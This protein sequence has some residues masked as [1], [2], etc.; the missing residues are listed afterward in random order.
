[1]NGH[2][3]LYVL[4]ALMVFFWSANFVVAKWVLR[5][6]PPLLLS[7]LR[8]AIAGAVITPVYWWQ[9]R[10]AAGDVWGK[11]DLPVLL[12]LGLFGVALNQLFFVLGVS[13]TSVAHSAFIIAMSPILVLLIAAAMRLE[14]ITKRKIAG[15][16]LAVSGVAIL[17]AFPPAHG[18]KPSLTGDVFIFLA[19][20][21]FALFTVMGKR[22]AQRHNPV[23][24][25]S[26]AYV[27]GAIALAP[28][29]LWQGSRF[30]FERVSA[31]GWAGLVY[32]AVF[33]SLI[34]YLI[35]Y[36]ALRRTSASRVASLAYLQPVVATTLAVALLGEHVTLPLMLGGAVIFSG[37]YLTER[38]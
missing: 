34:C 22:A 19:G 35:Y 32:M 6:F 12:Y 38:G 27:G 23:T 26:F 11:R 13:L 36:Y 8:V 17:N 37:V 4:L 1:L 29:T 24:V 18:P 21:T 3:V 15:M 16:A 2:A 28:F 9:A 33:P 30:A 20:L 7:G 31:A 25:T 10:R 5:E 14:R